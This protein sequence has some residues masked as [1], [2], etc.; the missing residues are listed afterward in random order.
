[1]AASATWVS[2]KRI[3]LGLDSSS[4][5]MKWPIKSCKKRRISPNESNGRRG[6]EQ[7]LRDS[8]MPWLRAMLRQALS[9]RS[10]WAG[11]FDSL[12]MPLN[13]MERARKMA[14]ALSTRRSWRFEMRSAARR[15]LTM[16]ARAAVRIVSNARFSILTLA[17][18]VADRHAELISE[19]RIVLGRVGDFI[20]DF[21]VFELEWLIL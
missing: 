12:G 6:S 3:M 15:S 8:D 13:S 2:V 1:M 7:I 21:I 11:S 20:G 10:R 17:L 18:P 19:R 4:L 16:W 5:C 9:L 14:A